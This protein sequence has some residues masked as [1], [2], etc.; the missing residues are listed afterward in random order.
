MSQ[1]TKTL[2]APK[3]W[4]IPRKT[5]YWTVST[6]CG[7]HPIERSIPLLII[8]R[9]L[10]KYCDNAS[11]GKRL[12]GEK[13]FLVDG[14]VCLDYR[15][16]VGLMDVLSIPKTNEHFRVLLDS[17]GKL[18][19]IKINEELSKWKLARVE[20]KT[21]IKK[22]RAQLHLHDGRNILLNNDKYKAGDVLKID[23]PSQKVIDCY[24]LSPGNIAML[25]GGKHK[26][27]LASIID[28]EI[29]RN[30]KP[31]IVH[32]EKFSTTKNNVFVVGTKTPEIALP[33]VAV[34]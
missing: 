7:P 28:Y 22:G 21:T 34:V 32:F 2:T 4:T 1:H 3:S 29:T 30:P 9:D 12:I 6:R 33:E 15:R 14:K 31:N 5:H 25:I 19:I 24:P 20:G 13:T 16:S 18:R 27:E 10:L 11:E 26:G 8:I 17:R 23:I